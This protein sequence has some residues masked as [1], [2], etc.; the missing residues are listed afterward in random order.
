MKYISFKVRICE[1]VFA[2]IFLRL[3][4]VMT[5]SLKLFKEEE[6]AVDGFEE[7]CAYHWQKTPRNSKYIYTGRNN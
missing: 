3:K 1:L 4:E 7:Y 6:K 2:D 5:D